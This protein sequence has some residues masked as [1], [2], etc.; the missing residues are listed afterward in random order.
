[1]KK[2]MKNVWFL[3]L[4]IVINYS[5]S[6]SAYHPSSLP[7]LI[8]K[9]NIIVYGRIISVDKFDFTISIIKKVKFNRKADNLKIRKSGF[10]YSNSR[11]SDYIVGQEAIYFLRIEEDKEL[12]VMGG[13]YAGEL[14]VKEN[15]SYIE[16]FDYNKLETKSYNFLPSYKKYITIDIGTVIEGINIY[17]RNL[18][19]I[20][21]EFLQYHEG[22]IVYQY[23]YIDRLPHNDFLSIVL[24]Q[25]RRQY[26][27]VHEF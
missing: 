3:L 20:N 9:S 21:R 26:P 24:K 17:L 23:S 14:I 7:D 2:V 4:F 15:T 5:F 27:M 19:V 8:E 18:E 6:T 13:R 1:M 11:Y 22:R 16:D 12:T 10:N 25:K